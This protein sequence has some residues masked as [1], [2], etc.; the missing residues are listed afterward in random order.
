MINAS[1]R[2]NGSCTEWIFH[3]FS[4]FFKSLLLAAC[5]FFSLSN[6]KTSVSVGF[7]IVEMK[8]HS[9]HKLFNDCRTNQKFKQ[10][11]LLSRRETR[12]STL[13]E[14]WRWLK[15][16]QRLMISWQNLSIALRIRDPPCLFRSFSCR[17]DGCRSPAED[18]K[19]GKCG[20]VICIS[21]SYFKI[22]FGWLLVKICILFCVL[23]F[24]QNSEW[25]TANI[26]TS[27]LKFSDVDVQCG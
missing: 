2:W 6:H 5:L 3:D 11:T 4:T 27:S 1:R 10:V 8:F 24:Q 12:S 18:K 7:T 13:Q 14:R 20:S 16:Y 25:S 21:W 15:F 23:C 9:F 22:A 17:I 26:H 19:M